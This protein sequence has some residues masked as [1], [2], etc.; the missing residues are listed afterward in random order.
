MRWSSM[1]ATAILAAAALVGAPVVSAPV[2]ASSAPWSCTLPATVANGSFTV[3]VY[4]GRNGHSTGQ[5]FI[6]DTGDAAADLSLN[7]QT[8]KALHDL[9]SSPGT[10]AI[11][12]GGGDSGYYTHVAV[13]LCGRVFHNQT[14]TVLSPVTITAKEDSLDA[15]TTWMPD[16]IGAPFL[17][18]SNL[19]LTVDPVAQTVTFAAAPA[20]KTG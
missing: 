15:G 16:L 7:D 9:R 10:A 14:A 12:I 4:I 17:I 1:R 2:L 11:G 19:T 20:A 6:I 5:P 8:A 3:T 13:N 18:D